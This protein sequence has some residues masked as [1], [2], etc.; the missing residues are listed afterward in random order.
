MEDEAMK[1]ATQISNAERVLI[2]ALASANGAQGSAREGIN[3]DDPAKQ[4]RFVLQSERLHV[5]LA[6]QSLIEAL[7]EAGDDEADILA[8]P[9]TEEDR[10]LLTSIL[11]G[12]TLE[13]A[14]RALR[15]IHLRR[16]AAFT[17]TSKPA[18]RSRFDGDFLLGVNQF[19]ASFFK[20]QLWATDKALAFCRSRGISEARLDECE[21]GYAPESRTEFAELLQRYCSDEACRESGL[22]SW[23]EDGT[24]LSR[25]HHRLM[26]PIY[27][28]DN[29]VVAFSGLA[30]ESDQKGPDWLEFNH[31]ALYSAS[32]PPLNLKNVAMRVLQ[33][34]MFAGDR[35]RTERGWY[36]LARMVGRME[37]RREKAA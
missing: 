20:R 6:S 14:V 7:L 17:I 33:L 26:F 15:S 21:V 11:Q 22:L 13:G 24:L 28:N 12:E 30:I 8:V 23:K 9:K 10:R 25:F 19:A 36:E 4:A 37:V 31:T 18:D 35:N 29:R 34:Q 32:D 16:L 2:R 3:E 1:E 5:G 27:D